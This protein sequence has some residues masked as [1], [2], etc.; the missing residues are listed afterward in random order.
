MPQKSKTVQELFDLT[1]RVAVVTGGSGLYGRQIAEALAEA[2][3]RTIMA[4]RNLEKLREQAEYFG[5]NGLKVEVL[6]YDQ[7]SEESCKNLLGQVLDLAGKV[8]VLVNNSVLRT[9]KDW[10]DPAT[11]FAKSMEVNATGIFVM[12]RVF[13]DQMAKQG[14]GSI[15]N[16][17]SI[18][19]VVGPDFTLYEGLNWGAPPDYFFHKGGLLQLTRY[20]AS[21]LGP[22]GVRVNAISPGGYFTNQDESFVKRYNARTFL[23]RMANDTDIKGG[24]VFLASDASEYVTGANLAVDAGY[25]CK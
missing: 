13:G 6:Q 22:R 4:S 7:S 14:S 17:G 8:D 19:G 16:V 21:V 18:Q 10:G 12:T 5:K 25:T 1:G 11:A 2:G 20:A 3:A 9:M 24:I 23:G 15:I